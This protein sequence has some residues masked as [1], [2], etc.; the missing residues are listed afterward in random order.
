MLL[1]VLTLGIVETN[2]MLGVI[3]ACRLCLRP[4]Q[5]RDNVVSLIAAH[6]LR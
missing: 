1:R 4:C 3:G 6:V 5:S 2:L